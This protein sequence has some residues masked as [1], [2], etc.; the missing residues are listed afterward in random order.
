LLG[1]NLKRIKKRYKVMNLERR[2]TMSSKEIAD[3]TG[4]MHNDVLK[5]IRIME[6][7]WQ[8]V[9]GGNFPLSEYTDSTGRKLPMYQL[10][11]T[12]CLYIATKFNDEARA[13]LIVRWEQLEKKQDE[14]PEEIMARALFVAQ[15]TI[16]RQKQRVQILEG[17]NEHLNQEV[18][19]L[20]PKAE[21]T[22]NVLQSTSTYTM[23]Q[24]AKELGMS[25]VALE[26]KLHDNG[27][28]FRQSVQW[29]L[30][31]K[32]QNR[33]YA[34]YRTHYYTH[35]DGTTGTNTITVWTEEGRKFI[36][37]LSKKQKSA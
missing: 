10:N 37:E 18:N 6:P 21:Y 31:A 12:E 26:K 29:I 5:A 35:S 20:A 28:I 23:T 36:H 16:N 3:L 14:T 19:Q 17:E 2:E 25:A 15:D 22:D 24:V 11:K 1:G 9:T 27:V 33:G 30:Y 32:Y 13:R 7:S 8:K 4:K 34:K